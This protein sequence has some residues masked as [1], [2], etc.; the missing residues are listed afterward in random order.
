MAKGTKALVNYDAEFAKH[1]ETVAKMEAGAALG[2][3]FNLRGGQLTFGDA[4]VPGNRMAVVVVDHVLENVYYEGKFD[5]DSPS[6]PK[7]FAFGR[8][9]KAMVPHEAAPEKQAK[10]CSECPQNA[11]GTADSPSGRG[12]ACR[13]TRRLALIPAGTLAAN[14]SFTAKEDPSDFETAGLAYLKL[15]VTS[16]KGFAGFVHQIATALKRPPF[17]IFT[18]VSVVPDAKSQFKVQFEPL[19]PAPKPLF[20]VLLKRHEE[21]AAAIEFP[22]VQREDDGVGRGPK[23]SKKSAKGS[24]Y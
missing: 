16:V 7:C 6:G 13:N 17:G 12:K 23:K 15:P 4:P 3:F 19:E 10:A 1:A 22:Y 24:R 11:W 5:P 18:K 20:P 9:E 8:D 2:T 21:A 14:G